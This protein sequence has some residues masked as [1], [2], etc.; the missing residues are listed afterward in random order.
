MFEHGTMNKE[1]FIFSLIL[2]SRRN[3]DCKGTFYFQKMVTHNSIVKHIGHPH[4]EPFFVYHSFLNHKIFYF[5]RQPSIGTKF[6]PLLHKMST[7]HQTLRNLENT[8]PKSIHLVYYNFD[9][10]I[11]CI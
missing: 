7:F 9:C 4:F 10:I 11:T 8:I 5:T 3:K 2:P 1:I 6:S